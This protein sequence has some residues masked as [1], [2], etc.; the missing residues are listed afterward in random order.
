M[1]RQ[2]DDLR[3]IGLDWDGDVVQQSD[4]LPLY[5]NAIDDLRRRGLTYPCFCTRREIL[6]APSA[7]HAPD[8]AYPGT[9]RTLSE[10]DRAARIRDGRTPALRLRT[11]AETFTVHDALL[12]PVS[13]QVD[14]FVLLRGDGVP[15]YNLA[16]VVDDGAQGV[17][18]VV[19]GDDL[20]TSAPRQA[21][22]AAL[23]NIAAPTYAHV[24]LVLNTEGRRLA[25]RDGAVT[26][27]DQLAIGRTSGEV[28]T[29]IASTL[30]LADPGESV[31]CALLASRFDPALLP[32]RPWIFPPAP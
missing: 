23:L 20:L 19:R 17:D 4:R 25:K 3:S 1:T 27:A 15:A 31:T 24:P 28:L 26:L 9:C 18:Q 7:P 8:G 5:H 6:Q 29:L 14:D 30:G 10:D 13:A 22:L 32:R 16:V 11:D 21:Y 2:L 12:G